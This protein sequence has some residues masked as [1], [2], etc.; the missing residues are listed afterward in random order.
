MFRVGLNERVAKV[1]Q[2]AGAVTN[3]SDF[4]SNS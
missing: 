1:R 2:A 4:E 3:D